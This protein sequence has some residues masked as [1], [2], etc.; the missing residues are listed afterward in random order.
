MARSI[1]MHLAGGSFIAL[2]ALTLSAPVVAQ[3]QPPAE[4][5]AQ[6][7]YADIIVTANKRNQNINDVGL[8]ITAL[9]GDDL[10]NKG[11]S[12]SQDLAKV[13]P[14]FTVAASADGTPIYTLR[15]VGF[16]SS[17]LGA[18][19]TV[20]VYLD[21]A[22]LP[23]GPMTQG[24]IF[25]LERVEVL[26]GPQGTLFGQNSTGGAINYIAAKPTNTF[27]AGVVGSVGR[28]STFQGEAFVSGPLSDT[29]S[30]RLAVAGT[31]SGDWQ[32]NYTRDDSIGRQRKFAAR[33]I[34]NWEPTD[35][36]KVSLNLN[37]WIDKSDNQIPQF[38]AA[39]PRVPSQ[40]TPALFTQ[41]SAPRNDRAADWDVGR[42]F[43]RDNKMGQAV[44]RVDYELADHV[45]LTSLSN[46]EYVK[47]HSIFDND[48]TDL[49]FSYVTTSGHVEAFNQEVR[50]A[51][52]FG[53][54]NV[55]VG[56]NYST[57]NSYE[58]SLQDFGGILSS[59]TNVG[60][61]TAN[62]DGVGDI[63]FNENRG[64]QSNRSAAVFGN[65][66]YAI[67]PRVTLIGGVRYTD[68]K[69]TNQACSADAGDGSFSNVING[70]FGSPVTQP[71]GCVTLE[72]TD[73]GFA[74]PFPRQS[75]K[76]NNVAWRAGINF[77]PSARSLLYVLV[78]R[79]FKAGNYP[80][81]NATARSQFQPVRQEQLTAYEGGVKLGLFDR[82]V[83]LNGAVYYYDYKDKQL[84]TNTTDP[85][86]GLLPVLAN[87][88][89]SKVQ[90]FD[91]DATVRPVEGLTL[92]GALAYADS[93]I[94][95]F[96]GFDAFN[97]PTD[98]SGKSFNFAPKWTSTADVEY[99][100]RIN[101]RMEMFV[102]GDMLYNSTT[103]ADLAQT[104]SLRIAAYTIFGARVGVGSADGKWSAT[105]WG[106]NLTNKYYWYNTQVGY[107]TIWRLTGMPATYGVTFRLG[108]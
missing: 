97:T 30:A 34:L 44:L 64:K 37:G 106:K 89:K 28:F 29:L 19:P 56:G 75:F 49:G 104:Q 51:G 32:T 8:S 85:V 1:S 18:Q 58:S 21:E 26:K 68:I 93:K 92:R 80:V 7:D 20:S 9:D 47:I 61:T 60:A 84:L 88:P 81:I 71:G 94:K 39:S 46:Y 50:L 55:T 43:N 86:F 40:A 107:D 10:I 103:Y 35:A 77:K 78:S 83:Q 15:G 11:V 25:D 42:P 6:A 99:R 95:N 91:V 41:P 27:Q 102:G 17:N 65:L 54:A 67:T 45:T 66:E 5:A 24:P 53:A 13:V 79:G 22:A 62:P 14:A 59:T 108:F 12:S 16:N 31:H 76:E 74:A 70:L 52:Q 100:A 72:L 36:L 48:G 63:L 73:A 2:V 69:H 98:L 96:Q 57:D 82:K 101:G 38:F 90:G 33:A 105:V 4:A 23:Y 3:I 87:V